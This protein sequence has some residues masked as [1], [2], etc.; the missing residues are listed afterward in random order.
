MKSIYIGNHPPGRAAREAILAIDNDEPRQAYAAVA[1][2]L[3]TLADSELHLV[4]PSELSAIDGESK[5]TTLR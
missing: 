4:S 3:S 1:R 2:Q 5:G